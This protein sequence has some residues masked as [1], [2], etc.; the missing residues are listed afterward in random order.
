MEV[1]LSPKYQI[2]MPKE[3]RENLGLKKGQK[4]AVIV[5]NGV[6]SL[7]PVPS[8]EELRGI[9]KGIEMREVREDEERI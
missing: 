8:L 4:F 5:K 3:V 1:V 9:A 6:I 7:V 2:V